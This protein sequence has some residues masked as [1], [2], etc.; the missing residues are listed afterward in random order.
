MQHTPTGRK[1][2]TGDRISTAQPPLSRVPAPQPCSRPQPGGACA[3]RSGEWG[4]AWVMRAVP[5]GSAVPGVDS[6][7]SKA[8]RAG[9]A[10]L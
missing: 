5:W 8:A 4:G 2:R 3:L 9:S 7:R 6:F 10:V 1:R